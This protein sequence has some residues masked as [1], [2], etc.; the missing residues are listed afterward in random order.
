MELTMN[1]A[2]DNSSLEAGVRV[3]RKY[4][5]VDVD[6][7]GVV[8]QLKALVVVARECRA[9]GVIRHA[10]RLTDHRSWIVERELCNI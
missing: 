3:A 1:R 4:M 5:V 9:G 8:G 2:M 6:V 10:Q 7:T